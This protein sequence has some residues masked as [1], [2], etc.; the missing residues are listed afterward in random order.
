MP[1]RAI[2]LRNSRTLRTALLAGVSAFALLTS[3]APARAMQLGTMRGGSGAFAAT[4]NAAAAAM[5]SV[6]QAQQA[7]QQSMSSLT[8][9]MQAVQAMQQAQAQARAAAQHA[10]SAAP[11]LPSVPNGLTPGGLVPTYG[12]G[13]YDVQNPDPN[14]W[15]GANAPTQSTSNG[16]TLVEVQ[17]TQQKA[18]LT[19]TS[20]NVGANTTLYFNQSA[21]N[22][23]TGN[24]WIALNRVIDPSGVP[25]QILGQIKAEGTVY[26]I[27]HNGIVFGGGSQVNVSSL[28]ASSLPMFGDQ[29]TNAM[30]PGSGA[31]DTAVAASNSTFLNGG[32]TG[33]FLGGSS[34][35]AGD[36]TIDAGANIQSGDLGFTLIAAP[37]VTN[38]GTI[39]ASDGQILLLAGTAVT[40]SFRETANTTD[41]M[42][43]SLEDSG[44]NLYSLVNTGLITATTGNVTLEGY[45]VTQDGVVA[46]T[47]S[48][49]RPGSITLVAEDEMSGPVGDSIG[50]RVGPVTF[51]PQSVTTILPDEDGETTTSSASATAAFQSGTISAS[52]NSV[53]LEGDGQGGGALI[54]APS[55]SVSLVA[56]PD[57]FAHRASSDP[58]VAGRVYIDSGAVVDV[59]GLPDVQLPISANFVTI[60]PINANDLA[61]DPLQQNGFLLSQTITIDSRITGTNPETGQPWVGTP[62]IDAAGY[63]QDM[64]RTIDQMMINAGTID[65]AGGEVI[66]APGSVLNLTGGYINY[67]GGMVNPTRF[68]G[69]DGNIYGAANANPL[70]PIIGIAGR[71]TVDHSRWGVTETFT[72]PLLGGGYFEQG[73]IQG[74]NG[75]TLDIFASQF[76]A[77]TNGVPSISTTGATILDGT[78]QA[79]AVTGLYQAT[80]GQAPSGGSFELNADTSLL[81]EVY[82][83][84]ANAASLVPTGTQAIVIADQPDDDTGLPGDFTADTSLLTPD[85]RRLSPAD[86]S[87]ILYT[88][89][90]SAEQLDAAGFSSI[91]LKANGNSITVDPGAALTV[92]PGGTITFNAALETIDGSLIAPAGQISITATG[93]TTTPFTALWP[94]P[95]STAPPIPGN[96]TVGAGAVISAAGEWVNDANAATPTGSQFINGGSITLTTDESSAQPLLSGNAATSSAH[97]GDPVD[98][99]GSIILDSGSLLDVSSGGYVQ[100]D[101]QLLVSNDVP[102]GK[103]GAISLITYAEDTGGGFGDGQT[104][105]QLPASQPTAGRIV[106]DGTLR[107]YGFSADAS[108]TLQTLAIQ[109]GGDASSAPSYALV[110]P[111]DFFADA[112]FGS[113]NLTSEYDTTIAA[114]TTMALTQSNFIP[115]SALLA[116]PTGTN[117]YGAGLAQPDGTLVTIGQL[118]PFHR[119]PTNLTINADNYLNWNFNGGHGSRLVFSGVTG[120]LLIDQGAAIV[121]DAGASIT[122]NADGQLTDLGSITAPGGT[123]AFNGL[124]SF[125]SMNTTDSIWLGGD[126]RIDVS[127]TV[128]TDPFAAPVAIDG[129][130]T[131]PITGKVLSGGSVTLLAQDGYVVAQQGAEIDAN[132]ASG[133]FDLPRDNGAASLSPIAYGLTPVWSDGGQ[134]TLGSTSGLYFDGTL[135]AAGGASQ[136]QGG[137]L[138]IQGVDYVNSNNS[139]DKSTAGILIQQ[140]GSFVPTGLQP[141]Q[142]VEASRTTPSG[143]DYFD[144]DTLDG[145][146]I[147]NLVLGNNPATGVVGAANN[148]SSLTIAF[149]GPVNLTLGQSIIADASNYMVLPSGTTNIPGIAGTAALPTNAVNSTNG[150]VVTISAPYVEIGGN[151]S[152]TSSFKPS[153]STL[154]TGDGTLNVSAEV[155]DLTGRF[156]LQNVANASFT[157]SGDIRLYTLPAFQAF[158]GT[159]PQAGYL[160]TTG[161]VT[162]KASDI[163][164]AT[165]NSFIID[166]VNANAVKD[167]N[168]N[169]LQT[170]VTILGNGASSAPLSAGGSLL[171]DATNILQDGTLRAPSGSITLGVSD[172]GSAAS[173]FNN[174]PLVQT[175][176]VELGN[177]STTSVSLDGETIPFGTTVDGLDFQYVN[178][179]FT[180]T[181]PD[182]TAPPVKV[183]SLAGSSITLDPDATVDLTGGGELQAQEWVPGTGGSRNVL[184]QTNTDFQNGSAQPVQVPLF[185]DDRQI[186]AIIPGFNGPVAPFDP[187]FAQPGSEVGQSVYLSGVPGL[188]AG[189]YTLLPAQYATL[190]GAFR[191]VQ[192]TNVSNAVASQNVALADGTQIIAGTFTNSLTGARDAETTSFMVQ[193]AA[194]W[195][196]YSQYR[197][198]NADTFFSSQAQQNGTPMPRL[199]ADAGQLA[200]AA[201]TNLALDATLDAT[202]GL[203]GRGAQV[204]IA[205]QDIEIVGSGEA[206]LPGYLQISADA[207]D[208]LGAESLLIGGTRTDTA[209]GETITAAAD[210]VVVANDAADPLA[211][212]EIILVTK[213][214]PTGKDPNA[215]TGL[216]VKSGS[217]I[218]AK[219]TIAA[220]ADVPITIG[221]TSVSGDG[222]LL[223]VSNGAPVTVTRLNV[224]TTPLGLLDVQAGTTLAGGQS[225]ILDSAGNTLVDPSAALSG[226][227]ITADAATITFVAGDNTPGNGLVIGPSTLAQFARANT[228][229][230]QSRGAM[231]FFGDINVA[232]DHGT[233]ELGAGAFTTSTGGN[234]SVSAPTLVLT[235]LLGAQPGTWTGPTNGS[236]TLNADEIDFGTGEQATSTAPAT[237]DF[238]GF[239]TVTANATSAIVAQGTGG[240]FDFGSTPVTLNTPLIQADTG[241][242]QTLKTTGAL[243]LATADGQALQRQSIGGQVTLIGGSVNDG[244]N[245]S[246]PAGNVNLEATS[247][248][249]VV[250]SSVT[251][252][253]SGAAKQFFDVTEF[254]PAGAISLVA[255]Q[256]NVMVAGGATLDFAGNAGGGNAGQLSI[257]APVGVATLQGAVLQGGAAAGFTGGSLSLTTGG[258]ADLDALAQELAASGVTNAISVTSGQGNLVLSAG[259]MITAEMVSLTA[260]GGTG[261]AADTTDGNVIIA[262]TINAN[263]VA[264]SSGGAQGGIIDLFGKSSVDLEGTLLAEGSDAYNP[265]GTVNSNSTQL[266]GT[267]NIGT[268]GTPTANSYN[269][270]YGYE[271]VALANSG[272]IVLGANAVIDVSGGGPLTLASDGEQGG[273]V[274]LRAP[275]LDSDTVDVVVN[276]ANPA[277]QIRGARAVDLEAYAVWSTTDSTTGAQHFDGIIDPAGWYDSSGNLLAG[278]FTNTNTG[279]T[280]T[281]TPANGSTP[282]SLSN[283]PGATPAQVAADLA[284]DLQNDFFTPT[285]ANTDPTR[286]AH[287]T[288]YGFVNGDNTA[289]QPGT[290]MGFVENPGFVTPANASA[291]SNFHEVP[292]IELDNPSSNINHGAISVLTD[293]NL[294]ATNAGGVPLFRLNG[295]APVFTLRAAGD[296]NIDASVSDGFYQRS[297]GPNIITQ[298][299]I[300]L[301]PAD[302]SAANSD[303]NS[304]TGQ[305]FIGYAETVNALGGGT[306]TVVPGTTFTPTTATTT[307]TYYI[308][309]TAPAAGQSATYYSNYT[310]SY[311]STFTTFWGSIIKSD[312]V[313]NAKGALTAS[314]TITL[315]ATQGEPIPSSFPNNYA[316]YTAA[317]T[318]WLESNPLF[319][320]KSTSLTPPPPTP[321]TNIND[322]ATY[323]LAWKAYRNYV[324]STLSQRYV[325]SGAELYFYPPAPPPLDP[326]VPVLTTTPVTQT[327]AGGNSPSPMPTPQNPEALDIATLAG[328]SSSSYRFVAGADL[329]SV[330]PTATELPATFA[331]GD[332]AGQGSVTVDGHFTVTDSITSGLTQPPVI[333]LPTI[334]RTGTGSIDIAAGNDFALL[335]AAAPGVVYT[336]GMPATGTTASPTVGTV[337]DQVECCAVSTDEEF[338]VTGVVNPVAGGDISISAGNDILGTEQV[339]DTTGQVTGTAGVL[340]TQFWWQWMEIGNPTASGTNSNG[341]PASFAEGSSINFGAFDQGVMSVGGNV[342]IDAGGNISDLAVSLPTTWYLTA[343]GARAPVTSL[344]VTDGVA[345]SQGLTVN[346]VGG[347]NLVV[348]AGGDILSG[349][350][351]VAKGTGTITA[352]GQIGSDFSYATNQTLLTTF[353]PDPNLASASPVGTLFALQDATL[354]VTARQSVDIGGIFDPSLQGNATEYQGYSA[355]SAVTVQSTT[356]NV[357]LLSTVLS[358]FLL[359]DNVS[360]SFTST[361]NGPVG[362]DLPATLDVVAFNGGISVDAPGLLSPSAEGGLNLIADQTIQFSQ[363]NR[364][365]TGSTFGVGIVDPSG[366][367]SPL[368]PMGW[369]PMGTVSN[370]NV[371]FNGFGSL[372]GL[373][374]FNL[375]DSLHDA[376]PD[377]VRIYALSGDI[378]DGMTDPNGFVVSPLRLQPNMP[379][380]IQAGQDIVDL[381]FLGQNYDASDI[382]RI[383]AGRDIL[384][385]PLGNFVGNDSSNDSM[386]APPVLELAGPGT[387]D[388]EAGRNIGPL[389]SAVEANAA[390]YLAAFNPNIPTQVPPTGIQTIGNANDGDLP[391]ESASVVTLFGIGPGINTQGFANAYLDP[392]AMLPAGVSSYSDQ[393]VA[394][395][396]QY[397][398]DQNKKFGIGGPVTGLTAGQAWAVFETLPA[399]RQ[400]LL[401]DQVFFDILDTTGLDFNNASSPFFHQYARGYEAINTLFPA[402]FGYTQNNLSGGS[403]GSNAPVSTGFLDMRGSTI[404]TQQGGNVSILGPGGEV[405]VGSASAPPF[406]VDSTGHT[407]VGPNQMGIL[408]L[409]TGDIDIFSD[410]SVLLAQSRIFTE[411]GGNLVIWSSNGDINAGQGL[412]TTAELPQEVFTCDPDQNCTINPSGEVT[413]A[414]IAT[415]QTIPG[416]PRGNA[417][418]IAPRGTIDAGAAGIRVS[419]NLNLVALQVVNAF[420][421]QVQGVT[422]GLSFVASPSI[423]ALTSASNAAGAAVKQVA[424]P[425]NKATTQASILIVEIEGYGGD[426]ESEP[427]QQPQPDDH[428]KKANGQ[429]ANYDPNGMFRVVGNGALSN[430]EKENL[431]PDE[432]RGLAP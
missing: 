356:G 7:T 43:V 405:L 348:S 10:T 262:G 126:S 393:L 245:I 226:D 385:T 338:L 30:I 265:D 371:N 106:M 292:G 388:V 430:E 320:T 341:N 355:N 251:I 3:G 170:N 331:S 35:P 306:F 2:A 254:A 88:T 18:I 314:P 49:S 311:Y 213:T 279:A 312:I 64:P 178:L 404:Q 68:L 272:R 227:A 45:S 256:G 201:I 27:N 234:V 289:A 28:V 189:V 253:V 205:S 17:Q 93:A 114:G 258:S 313:T 116:A 321:P 135:H 353:S 166:A 339:V 80:N 361:S 233:L 200:I 239:G 215:P 411:E 424:S 98:N 317:Y 53:T 391:A 428:H 413:G 142:T 47:T 82:T 74:G 431:T 278:T 349:D 336:A 183:I 109:I 157:S 153:A 184:L 193:S 99:T 100:P 198:T 293:W 34:N 229:I 297:P 151:N 407:L 257:A 139:L 408:T 11:G 267:I 240:V 185:A 345:A 334:V 266:G 281:Y 168:G 110:L 403:N 162:L 89:T 15:S 210:S 13:L 132:G 174:L 134:I 225:L 255:D 368:N 390:G 378:D 406:V 358:N 67:Q 432:R 365:D 342:S 208:T 382:T 415:L 72:A 54:Y 20:F 55:G 318:A 144:A 195:G 58:T 295:Q 149:A 429:R 191:V 268:T 308:P 92:A 270:Q 296:I 248:D 410:Q 280:I 260:N 325:G 155:L 244:V 182:L 111:A 197:L 374:R 143:I 37:N 259:N 51:G 59:S 217:V 347:G 154:A 175:Q 65:L 389:T 222:A 383:V 402:S 171:I 203:G 40:L 112:G 263:G 169:P 394:F 145:S 24:N 380:L 128:L 39:D 52:G 36:I 367:A 316:G 150:A 294:G 427:V 204:D 118:D 398:T 69:A 286:T 131:I 237:A 70:V 32:L 247:G 14:V 86:P 188:P 158:S 61:D 48:I 396:E 78:V 122:L 369:L 9:A 219:G 284:S 417:D 181:T 228:I 377:P 25:S 246:A 16:Q 287:E 23:S 307:G 62:L 165:D 232:L 363:Q 137:T 148:V 84:T 133:T 285:A 288:F 330:D 117:L 372:T 164:P 333:L 26:I 350:Y 130:L 418:L 94:D 124:F 196:R 85:N 141:G 329:G 375:D 305:S 207:L 223:E 123:V 274:N 179:G 199:A 252:D 42:S 344:R 190:P 426:D 310:T 315:A 173:A 386:G 366:L 392:A 364:N 115:S 22:S 192:N 273:I 186:Y 211:G 290:L 50:G 176:S 319:S 75:G 212:P 129:V 206:A 63:V 423:G 177:D 376:D 152:G 31:Y 73:Y 216:L 303:F 235:N 282:A 326:N 354:T 66:T 243:T 6:Q 12:L 146:G 138:T 301:T 381:T 276:L 180:G 127:G 283:E 140:S 224:P 420:N 414:G 187:E 103:G 337:K 220:D 202:P 163:Y 33:T 362:F 340:T 277:G 419:G 29:S 113:Y 264:T 60:G 119:A 161:D 8:R 221:S 379:A 108:L 97:F 425:T 107:G 299:V 327:T 343:S 76:I 275:L 38:A 71:F 159:T 304:S 91:S 57:D 332:L 96:I 90:L 242:T 167:A 160:V 101:G 400:Q 21:G 172:T 19:W 105:P 399:Y 401:V 387:F 102:V 83:F 147:G 121:A 412:K 271:N 395:V 298:T 41:Q 351:F 416:A 238:F 302:P 236:L 136:A 44:S 5:A 309:L 230:L 77:Q 46:A 328:G 241:S 357:S 346:T 384:D 359:A 125:F 81:N 322:Y 324:F 421:I 1:A 261:G 269:I 4:A 352:G 209:T 120:T 156:A 291:I 104:S 335:D 194:V 397:E 214:D 370:T 231:D 218:E 250:D 79:G 422:T 409:E 249:L 87:N 323:I 373:S 95:T 360:S 300:Q 56:I